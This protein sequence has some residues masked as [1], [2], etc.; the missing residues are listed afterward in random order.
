MPAGSDYITPEQ[1]CVGLYIH[2]DLGWMDHPFVFSSFK[3]KN[4]EQI[5]TIRKLRLAQ[6]RYEQPK[7]DSEPL[8]VVANPVAVVE[9]PS[10]AAAAD[11]ELMAAK[12]ARIDQLKHIRNEISRV[13]HEFMRAAEAVRNI[14]RNI[15]A[16]PQEAFAATDALVNKMVKSILDEGDVLIHAMSDKLGD[17]VYFHSLNV[18]VLSLMLA[19]ALGLSGEQ[20]HELGMGAM[21][22]DIG[23]SEIPH[24]IL[25]KIEPLTRPEQAIV[26][27]HCDV[28]AAFAKKV[29]L[30]NAALAIILQ[31]HEYVDGSGYP[32]RLVGDKISPLARLLAIVNTYDNLCNPTNAANALTPSEALSRMFAHR[33]AQFD[34]VML[35]AFIH[36]LGVYPPGSIV[37][38]SNDMLGLVLSVNPGNPLRPDVL[39][40]DADIPKDEAIVVSLATEADLK[41]NKSLRPSELPREVHQ[42][43]NPRARVTYYCDSQKKPGAA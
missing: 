17:D 28:G 33:R 8:P 26:E 29:G 23:K 34:D 38:L 20:M 27:Q 30:S 7:S 16:R 24:K 9:T 31:H 19:Q 21:L 36:C 42:Y 40:Y 25:A 22:H 35:K 39:I 10:A 37:Q 13:E 32:R 14:T 2:L 15:H 43:L 12:K 1:L 6:I 18:T 41:I 4:Q 5:D 3:I 11:I